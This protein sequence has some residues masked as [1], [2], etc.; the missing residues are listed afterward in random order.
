MLLRTDRNTTVR[1]GD[2][3]LIYTERTVVYAVSRCRHGDAVRGREASRQIGA[4]MIA[5]IDKHHSREYHQTYKNHQLAG[6]R[7]R[8]QDPGEPIGTPFSGTS[9]ASIVTARRKGLS[10]VRRPDRA[11]CP[12]TGGSE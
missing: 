5:G 2:K 9:A 10:S 6:K 1:S 7:D 4:P 3:D 8:G 12:V 11:R